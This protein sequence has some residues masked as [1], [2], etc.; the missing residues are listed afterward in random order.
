M[1][2]VLERCGVLAVPRDRGVFSDKAVEQDLARLLRGASA[3][4]HRDVLERPLTRPA[5]AAVVAFAE[6]MVNSFDFKLNLN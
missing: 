6:V 3:E 2:A 5:I 1:A 4:Q